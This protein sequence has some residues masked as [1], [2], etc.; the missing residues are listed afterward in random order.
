MKVVGFVNQKGGVG[1]TTLGMLTCSALAESPFNY[2]IALVECDFQQSARNQRG[3]DIIVIAEELGFAKAEEELLSQELALNNDSLEKLGQKY[4]HAIREEMIANENSYFKYPIYY[5]D[6][7]Q[8]TETIVKLD[9]ED[10]YDYV[11]IDMPGQ[12]QGSGLSTLLVALDYAFV[13]VESGDFDVS[14]S[15]DFIQKKMKKFKQWKESKGGTAQLNICVLFNKVDETN[16]YRSVIQGF[17]EIF[18]GDKDVSII[19]EKKCLT[20]SIF[21]KEHCNTYESALTVK[22]KDK[23]EMGMQKR[24]ATFLEEI[25]NIINNK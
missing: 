17:Q 1:K 13:P 10:K 21:Y 18:E 19:D 14:S 3:K 9:D 2:K 11:F 23:R 24:F 12:A 4:T 8:L 6:P 25:L 15:L 22:V 7:E 20:R 16:V 5:S